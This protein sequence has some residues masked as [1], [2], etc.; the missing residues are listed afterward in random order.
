MA[1]L[2]RSRQSLADET[3]E[4]AQSTAGG[5]SV[6]GV[7]SILTGLASTVALLFSAVS[8]YHSVLKQPELQFHVSPVVHYTRDSSGNLEVFAVPLTIANHGARDGIVLDVEL[9]AQSAEGGATKRFYSAYQ[10]DGDFFVKPGGFD[11][12][13]RRF[14]RV[15]RPKAPFAP[16]SVAGRSNFTGTLLFYRKDKAFPKI[17]SQ[18]GEYDITLNLNVRLDNSLGAVDQFLAK[19]PDP[20]SK[21]VKLAYFSE[22]SLQRGSTHQLIDVVWQS[23]KPEAPDVIDVNA[24]PDEATETQRA[25]AAAPG[26]ASKAAEATAPKPAVPSE[27]TS[28]TPAAQP[29]IHLDSGP[30]PSDALPKAPQPQ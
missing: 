7:A 9:V 12:Q 13:K 16:I 15:D 6:G 18:A 30:L 19:A 29:S 10:V 27:K 2:M 24:K 14:E 1:K 11:T 25:G 17:V 28:A 4:I 23:G 5:G 8:L 22:S 21:R 20:V 26:T 3:T